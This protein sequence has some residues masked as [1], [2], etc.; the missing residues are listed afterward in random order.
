[1]AVYTAEIELYLARVKE[2]SGVRSLYLMGSIG[3][4]GL[5]DIDFVVVLDDGFNSADFSALSCSGLNPS[6]VLHGPIVVPYS[7]RTKLQHIVYASNLRCIYGEDC[8]QRWE[9]LDDFSARMLAH[10]YII[11]FL[12][13]RFSQYATVSDEV[14]KRVWLTRIWSITHTAF[15]F[16][17]YVGTGLDDKMREC[18]GRIRDTRSVWM[19]EQHVPDELFIQAFDD[20]YEL[21]RSLFCSCIETLYGRPTLIDDFTLSIGNKKLTF[22]ND[23]HVPEYSLESV[24]LT[25][26]RL[27]AFKGKHSPGYL[28]HL[29]GYARINPPWKT[30]PKCQEGLGVV[31]M[32]RASLVEQLDTWLAETIPRVGALKGYT[33]VNAAIGHGIRA[34][35]VRNL[36]RFFL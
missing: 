24:P 17:K 14:D 8:L 19:T 26:G 10:C 28:A 22:K 18:L 9:D 25:A 11:D 21:T 5:S 33:G 3:A 6:V 35:L 13:S 36:V 12:E 23:L 4:P 34:V 1:M 15:L 20:S 30:K 31:K 29:E 27:K 32:E 16:E 7:L 2:I